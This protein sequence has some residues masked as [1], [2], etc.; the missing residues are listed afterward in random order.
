MRFSW[1]AKIYWNPREVS[2]RSKIFPFSLV[3][4]IGCKSV[5]LYVWTG[6]LAQ[7]KKTTDPKFGTHTLRT[8]LKTGLFESS[9]LEGCLIRKTSMSRGFSAYLLDRLVWPSF[10]LTLMQ[11]NT[12]EKRKSPSDRLRSRW[13][14]KARLSKRCAEPP[15]P[16]THTHTCKKSWLTTLLWLD[17]CLN[18]HD[19]E[20]IGV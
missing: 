15:P 20:K 19:G 7:I 17:V 2:S 3:N 14:E 13:F 12:C 10:W 5:A 6:L 1:I 11:A 8:C 9:D 16:L 18:K 4:M